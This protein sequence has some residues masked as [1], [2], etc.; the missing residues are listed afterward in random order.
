MP[1]EQTRARSV[2]LRLPQ[3][4]SDHI[5]DAAVVGTRPA[6]PA[7]MGYR[8]NGNRFVLTLSGSPAPASMRV[9]VDAT[10]QEAMMGG[11]ATA[12]DLSVA[13]AANGLAAGAGNSVAIGMESVRSLE[14]PQTEESNRGTP[15]ER[16]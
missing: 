6:S 13:A 12:T 5:G 11:G 4:K 3:L 14:D 1:G 15:T 8:R 9:S 7:T 10:V 16:R 2:R